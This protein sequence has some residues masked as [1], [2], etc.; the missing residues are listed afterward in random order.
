M[1][2]GKFTAAQNKGESG[3][4]ID[5][6][7]ELVA[8]CE[9]DGF[10]PRYYTDGPQDKVDRTLE[11]L[12]GYTKTLVTEEMNLG[13]MIESSMKEIMADKEREAQV[14]ADNGDED[15]AFEAQLFSDKSDHVLTDEDFIAF[16]EMEDEQELDD[17]EYLESLLE[18]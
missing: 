3:E 15:D 10:I 6:V 1:K 13:N 8:I 5:S 4:F 11:D 14:D 9:R 18:G 16:R 17:V 7:G 12:Q 2:S